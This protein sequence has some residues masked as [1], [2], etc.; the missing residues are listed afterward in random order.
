MEFAKVMLRGWQNTTPES[1]AAHCSPRGV[2]P[3]V[4]L[5]V[6]VL[7]WP[8]GALGGSL[9]RVLVTRGGCGAFR[10]A[11]ELSGRAQENTVVS[12][13]LQRPFGASDHKAG[14]SLKGLALLLTPL[15]PPAATLH[16]YLVL[17]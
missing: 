5:W 1:K 17:F 2:I 9:V 13:A 14:A 10:S 11:A 4:V 8:Q 16:P 3:V 7:C 15:G 12:S 6:A